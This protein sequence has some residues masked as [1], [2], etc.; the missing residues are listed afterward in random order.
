M[1]RKEILLICLIL[2][3]ICSVSAVSAADVDNTTDTVLATSTTDV[4]S[5]SNDL[6]SYSH[7]ENNQIL[8]GENDGAGSFSDLQSNITAAGNYLKLT[9]NYTYN[10][11]SDSALSSTG[12]IINKDFTLEGEEGKNI[13]IN[14]LS[15]S[16]LFKLD[17]SITL[18]NINFISGT[19]PNDA[20]I[21]SVGSLT[22]ENC[23]FANG[24]G[25]NGGAI[26]AMGG[27]NVST[28][29]FY[30]NMAR[31]G[32]SIFIEDSSSTSSISGCT[33]S[34]DQAFADG[35]SIN[36][37]SSLLT[38]Y[39]LSFDKCDA[40]NYGG[41][42]ML[43]GH[44]TTLDQINITNCLAIKN[45]GAVYFRHNH[46][47][48]SNLMFV[49]NEA[50]YGGAI[51]CYPE[52]EGTDDG[53]LVNVTFKGNIAIRNGGAM[54]VSGDNGRMIN[55]TF[56][57][58]EATYDGGA[59]VIN[60]TGWR[61]YN[62]T[63]KINTAAI[64]HGGAMYIENGTGI[65]ID[66]CNFTSN[67]AG[68]GGGAI[69]SYEDTNNALI[70]NSR[71]ISNT[72]NGGDGG[73][74]YWK[75]NNSNI[76]K[77]YF[78]DNKAIT[79]R[80]DT[81]YGGAISLSGS[82]D[83][84]YNCTFKQNTAGLDGGSIIIQ[85]AAG[86][87]LSMNNTVK[88]S[89]FEYNNASRNGGAI[90]WNINCR[91]GTIINSTFNNNSAGATAGAVLMQ[92]DRG[93]IYNSTFD[94][95]KALGS[96]P[97]STLGNGGAIA[98]TGNHNYAYN[99]TFRFNTADN[100]GGAA[101]V[102]S[103]DIK[104]SNDTTFVLCHFT[105]NTAEKNGGAVDWSAGS[106]N[107]NIFNSTFEN[108]TAKR[109]G[110]AVYWSGTY[111][112]VLYSTFTNNLAVGSVN[113]GDGGGDGGAILWIGSHGQ[114]DH[115][116]FTYNLAKYRGGAVY[117]KGESKTVHSNDTNFTY[118]RFINNTAELNGGAIDW[119]AGANN[120]R[121]EH[122][123]FINNT[124]L[125]SAGAVFWYGTNGTMEDC[126]FTNNRATGEVTEDDRKYLGN[127]YL[128]VGGNGGA[129]VW[130]GS[131]GRANYV[132]FENNYA[133]NL[134][135]A[136]YLE[137]NDNVTISHAN[138]TNNWADINGGA[139]D[140]SKGAANGRV[141][142]ANFI[143]NTAK[144]SGGAIYWYGHNGTLYNV[145]F[146]NNRALGNASYV[147]PF[148]ET[149]MGGDGGAV[150]WT[151]YDGNVT[152]SEF[153]N[154]SA[155]KRGGAVFL[156]GT[157]DL[158]CNNTRF[159]I[160]LFENNTAGTNGGAVDWFS[161][162]TNGAI[163]N[164]TFNNNIANRSGGAIYWNGDY[165]SIMH[166][167]FTNNTAKGET[168][169]Y[170]AYGEYTQGG[171]GGA[172]I[173]SGSHGLV[174]DSRFI[175]NTAARHGG[176]VYMQGTS[177]ENCTN[178][179]FDLCHFEGN[180]ATINGG[181]LDWHEGAHN[182]L[183]NN[184]FFINNRARANG[185]AI[186]WSGHDGDII[187]SNFTYN[188]ALGIVSDDNGNQGDGGA[189]IWSGINGD[190]D[191]CWFKFNNAS[192]RGGAVY[193][194][195]CAH[196]NKNTTFDHSHFINNT[197]ALNGGAV[198][199]H[200]GAEHGLVNNTEFINNTAGVNGGAIFWNGYDG[201]I[202][203]SNFTNNFAVQNGGAVFWLGDIGIIN[204]SRFEYNYVSGDWN[205]STPTL[206][207]L[208][209]DTGINEAHYNITGGDGGAIMWKGSHGTIEDTT[210]YKNYSPYRGGAIFFTG[211]EYENCTNITI[212]KGNFTLNHAGL[213][214]GAVDWA[215]GAYNATIL[216]SYFNNNTAD[217][218]G[219]AIYVSG[220]ELDIEH[221][222]FNYNEV[223]GL[224]KYDNR[225]GV[226]NYTSIGAN[227]GAICW[228]GSYGDIIDVTFLNNTANQRGGAI[229]F[230]KNQN[231]TIR[232]SRF[233]NNTAGTEGG[234]I[235]FYHGAENADIISSNFTG[236]TAQENGGA[237]FW[238]GHYGFINGS[239]FEDN[240]AL[241]LGDRSVV[242]GPEDNPKIDGTQYETRYNVTGGDGGA[243]KWTG[244]HG[245]IESTTFY[246]NDAA[247]NGGALYFIGNS[248]EN[249][250]N[251]TFID[252][253]FTQNLAKLNGGAV[254]WA[255]GASN[256]TVS[257]SHFINNTAWRSAGAIYINGN[258]LEIDDTDFRY[259]DATCAQ[260]YDNRTG[261]SF[262]SSLGGNA[263]AICWMGSY[264]TVDNGTFINNTAAERGGAIQFETNK[265]GTVKNSWFEN[266]SAYGDGGAIDWYQ[267]AE[268]GR[269]I[270]STFLTNY[271]T[272]PNGRGSGVYIEG[273]NATIKDS[274]FKKHN[275]NAD[276]GVIYIEGN[277]ATVDNSTFDNIN[278]NKRG[279]AIYIHGNN[280]IVKESNFTDVHADNKGGVMYIDGQNT[281]VTDCRFN[282]TF[283][284]DDG[285][286]IYVTGLYCHLSNSTF[287][288]NTAGDDGGAIY[289]NGNYGIVYNITCQDTQA[290]SMGTHHSKGGAICLTSNYTSV[291]KSSFTDSFSSYNGGAMFITGNHVNITET[292]FKTCRVN[293]TLTPDG[294]NLPYGGA[295]Y[296]LGNYTN[297]YDCT[298]D[299]C[300]AI[301]GGVVYIYGH[302][303][304][305]NNASCNGS[306]ATQYGGSF[307]IDG[308]NA[309]IS[310]S[311]IQNS[312]AYSSGGAI[313]IYGPNAKVSNTTLKNTLAGQYGIWKTDGNGNII[314]VTP[315]GLGD[316][317]AIYIEGNNTVIYNATIT[318]TNATQRGGAIFVDGNNASIYVSV[319]D[320]SAGSI[321]IDLT[322]NADII[323]AN[324]DDMSSFLSQ[325]VQV[326]KNNLSS[327]KTT[328]TN[329]KNDVSKIFVNNAFNQ[330]YFDSINNRIAQVRTTLDSFI[331]ISPV[332]NCLLSYLDYIDADLNN[333]STNKNSTEF[334]NVLKKNITK[335]LD[336]MINF[337]D[338]ILKLGT[339]LN[340]AKDI[341]NKLF[342]KPDYDSVNAELN[343]FKNKFDTVTGYVNNLIGYNSTFAQ[344]STNVS[345]I[346]VQYNK[347]LSV[348]QACH[349]KGIPGHGGAIYVKG[350]DTLIHDSSFIN[351]YGLNGGNGG[352]INIA[353][354]NAGA[355]ARIINSN[356]T[357]CAVVT[358]DTKGGAIS[359]EGVNATIKGANFNDC[360]AVEK[361]GA[362]YIKGINTNILES[363][364]TESKTSSATSDGGAIYVDGNNATIRASNFVGSKSEDQGGAI[365]II[366]GFA[367]V[368]E[369]NFNSSKSNYGAGIYIQ[370]NNATVN[371][372]TF[373]KNNAP[374]AGG[375]IYS[376]GVGSKVYNSNFT[377]N[378]GKLGEQTDTGGGAIYWV[379][380]AK[381]DTIE[382]CTFIRND[383][384]FGGAIRWVNKAGVAASG[385][386]K[387]CTFDANHG[388]KGSVISWAS[389]NSALI[390]GC[391]FKNNNAYKNGCIYAG[392]NGM[393]ANGVGFNIS[394][395]EFI[396][397]SADFCGGDIA[398]AMAYAVIKNCNFTGS[399]AGYGG[400]IV[401]R[402]SSPIGT[403]IINCTFINTTSRYLTGHNDN[404]KH[405]GGAI[406]LEQNHPDIKVINVT[407]INS[408]ST[409]DG[410]AIKW[411]GDRGTLENV[412]IINS[413]AQG[414]YLSN[415]GYGGGIYWT[416]KNGNFT[417]VTVINAKS[418]TNG[419]GV[420][421][422]G[423]SLNISKS[424][425]INCTAIQ[426]GG[427]YWANT[428]GI[429]SDSNFTNNSARDGGAI[430][431]AGTSGKVLNSLFTGNNAT[432]G[433][434]VYWIGENG[435]LEGVTF[436]ENHADY[437]GAAYWKVASSKFTNN[438][439]YHNTADYGGAVYWDV[440][441]G[442]IDNSIMMY[443][444]AI[445]GS[446]IYIKQTIGDV[447]N[448]TLL[449]NQA[450]SY[451]IY[452]KETTVIQRTQNT[453]TVHTFF[454][455]GDN[456]LNAIYNAASD[457]Y[458]T[459]VTYLGVNGTRNTKDKGSRIC[460]VVLAADEY[461][462]DPNE[463]YQ[464]NLEVYQD[465]F[466]YTYDG[467]NKLVMNVTKKTDYMGRVSFDYTDPAFASQDLNVKVFHPE[468]NYYT[469]I[470]F[471][472]ATKLPVIFI[473][474]ENIYFQGTEYLN[475]T[476]RPLNISEN[477]PVT[478]GNLTIHLHGKD[479]KEY[480]AFENITL[481]TQGT[482][483]WAMVPISGLYVDTYS[484]YVEYCGNQYYV[485]EYNG[486]SFKVQMINSTIS[487]YVP[488]YYYGDSQKV[489]IQ[490]IRNASNT[491]SV[492][493]NGQ[494][495]W[496]DVDD[497]GY[498]EL[499]IPVL[500]AGNYTVEAFYPESRNCYASSNSTAFEVY[501]VNSTINITGKYVDNFNSVV[502]HVEVGPGDAIGFVNITFNGKEY[503]LSI[504][505]STADL[506]IM[507]V[508]RGQYTVNATYGGDINHWGSNN[509]AV[510]N[511]TKFT[512][513]IIIDVTNITYGENE[514]IIF[515]LPPNTAG[516]NLTITFNG[517]TFNK[518]IDNNGQVILENM[519]LAAG[520]YPVIAYYAGDNNYAASSNQ[521]IFNVAKA[522]PV[523]DPVVQ[524]I[525]Y[526][527][528]ENIIVN[529][530]QTGNVS[531]IIRDL[532]TGE[533][534]TQNLTINITNGRNVTWDIP[535]LPRGEYITEFIFSGNQNYTGCAMNRTFVVDY[536]TPL[537]IVEVDNI[538]F[539]D[540][541]TVNVTV[542]P[543]DKVTGNVTIY[544]DGINMG[545]FNLT[546]GFTQ[547][548]NVSGLLS[549][550]HDAVAVYNGDNNYTHRDNSTTFTVVLVSKVTPPFSVEGMNLTVFDDEIIS[551]NLPANATGMVYLKVNGTP[552]YLNLT[553]GERQINIGKLRNG[554]Y[555]VEAEYTGDYYWN[556]ISNTTQFNITKVD[557]I[558]QVTAENII[559]GDKA[560]L[561]ITTSQGICGNVTVNVNGTDYTA[562]V[563]GGHGLLVL[564]N[565]GVGNYPVEVTFDGCA[566]YKGNF[567]T[568]SFTVS[569][570]NATSDIR[571]IDQGNGTVVVV[572]PENATGYVNI[573]VGN[574]TF[575]ATVINGTAVITLENV[576]P[577][578]NN[579]T[580]FYS[581]DGNYTNITVN[582]TVTIPRFDSPIDAFV[583]S[584]YVGDVE[585]ITVTLPVNATGTVTIEINGVT[586][587]N[588]T[589]VGGIATFRVPNLAYGSKTVAVRYSGDANYSSN[590]TTRSF[591]IGR[592]HV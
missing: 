548:F 55:V 533:I 127:I 361:G 201:D 34:E 107:G 222:E 9:N 311:D 64:G 350:N 312:T 28:S 330:A 3:F 153:I 284:L 38:L 195:S 358:D 169:A 262:F 196:G 308:E 76:E 180:N 102:K 148:G 98:F 67:V 95:N 495:Y 507:N 359:V 286:A 141:E 129:V 119:Q 502:L 182:G 475:I 327:F 340:G 565:L 157:S 545:V 12:I 440:A 144:R 343:K 40:N 10:S 203:N 41:A 232:D 521:T 156:Q 571:V 32:G 463:I 422:G 546:D 318:S 49:K 399:Q 219:G 550:V 429:V 256:A 225:T 103:T 151:G 413:T 431:W 304:T 411:V 417:N 584:I 61:V 559:Y 244:S 177:T 230:E 421:V 355:N 134:G 444:R 6:S 393:G 519:T 352:A 505:N 251:I 302:N 484:V 194:Q 62:S 35:G 528:I 75:G 128:T 357:T 365:Y 345:N 370:G 241:G 204:G 561:N 511:A 407:I 542:Y 171:S 515:T 254:F 58:N 388:Y 433:G 72:A 464:T 409:T 163:L 30:K 487:V 105:N 424:N 214:G 578:V 227:G 145:S 576:T 216:N 482:S 263:G 325:I 366:G 21:N 530:N 205:R 568:T 140:W 193:I 296:V 300:T 314:E 132:N 158:E 348:V 17:G 347:I 472:N 408:T 120:G 207:Y 122:G 395:C 317:G 57:S 501:K 404:K 307:Y 497:T 135:G 124:A 574:Q 315:F 8:R 255:S 526:S 297:L 209:P 54:H 303:A 562:Y 405:G 48:L 446:A 117:L 465:I 275:T 16:K 174:Y 185:G 242:S 200:E 191:N 534:I 508:P 391:T 338:D 212:K 101:Y 121:L 363:N 80:A 332:F 387:N 130:S 558:I 436:I 485:P 189:I 512:T 439:L 208:N 474:A 415:P 271:I 452:N 97:G 88:D 592:A 31:N 354:N 346:N 349:N 165:G 457:I 434:A 518:T 172:V 541:A 192:A 547:L 50:M 554:T 250:T 270:N 94:G 91:N 96:F 60:G 33:F 59:I 494:Q 280:T 369:S 217:R 15:M 372:S 478:P 402:E 274:R 461:P 553:A 509:T 586:Y 299:N 257:D 536:A 22:V 220:N 146:K 287:K 467:N 133:H 183:I 466:T 99:T 351:S 236:N 73:A 331:T 481:N 581:G 375:A 281:T 166:S 426:G 285:G 100:H 52:C 456:L 443:N 11:S 451:E 381:G 556:G 228:M 90:C 266:N 252:C 218:S 108:N 106:I 188:Y 490:T 486:T 246:R 258:Y 239:R 65:T 19:S 290:I 557:S 403:Q 572:L 525:T 29:T 18:K 459:N 313:Y 418:K 294:D 414:K 555:T 229:Q 373:T 273:Y 328:L 159:T 190:V 139:I 291:N 460:A 272:G 235:D 540:N 295:A 13:T 243:I 283:S 513:P 379:G 116:N 441:G 476:V 448:T 51:Y 539:G 522:I 154:N 278:S 126:N 471:S 364:F 383:A 289:W 323:I 329:I 1:N 85:N 74:V 538:D 344:L 79:G 112:E 137:Q 231:A 319:R 149:T 282:D 131:V 310:N 167:N 123:V 397:N 362:I 491:V 524:N 179:T 170:N 81:G 173:W 152:R 432:N 213:N 186:F 450:L 496:V 470:V 455:G 5:I 298:F 356:F 377:E 382:N 309:T 211:T 155:V 240:K 473:E 147:N 579:I 583:H 587:T 66:N 462:S 93:S 260:T 552:Y 36:S 335:N 215:K 324:I 333:I 321:K 458:F 268:N 500:N 516:N 111:G 389:S 168:W 544:V 442:S 161:G 326:S 493:L 573:T 142:Y 400:S 488:N 197:A 401:L 316:G 82:Y 367:K 531:I 46:K 353:G 445:N 412:L 118:C 305:V 306:Y 223:T 210:F 70:N 202:V 390:T 517:Q 181:A 4:V 143:N 447:I 115:C 86:T 162:A 109:S 380:G 532:L 68:G 2:C 410:G 425:F 588:S 551:V 398:L 479:Y 449:E 20:P 138:F 406:Y 394:D 523:M 477:D 14:A 489:I 53:G 23:M 396:N 535:N 150:F 264:G 437:G 25:F 371:A 320:S 420:Y 419:G 514:T 233:I 7:S 339:S 226:L 589:I 71:F 336:S 206:Y 376:N 24:N 368:L 184:S 435:R 575:N 392:S 582:D 110:G 301:Q 430:Y 164:A 438:E 454:R 245:I 249:S 261:S 503:E 27:L 224:T 378:N 416:G 178:T 125:R 238:Q 199:W 569:K 293:N 276:G 374:M 26:H 45:G 337:V 113:D 537:I 265:N 423:D 480:F 570:V 453:I 591:K 47:L 504:T 322:S 234:A 89:T 590:F 221:S 506:T 259:N 334:D 510:I 69:N 44:N 42:I 549:G 160:A 499:D 292:E 468:D 279:G 563:S 187:N 63:F 529:I 83:T 198:D 384:G 385:L 428:N 567:N 427:I 78:K 77:S 580:V 520:D 248:T 43:S 176:A 114:V 564:D 277:K 577:G 341:A 469:Y 360:S 483:G 342:D 267:G 84:I 87:T 253:N 386:I 527:Q 543:T 269:L 175:N 288:N 92:S 247:Y 37:A 56:E 39:N 560:V 585:E 498:A 136:I 237:I 492:I 566:K 104:N